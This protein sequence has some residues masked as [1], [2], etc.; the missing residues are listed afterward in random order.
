MENIINNPNV[1][2]KS[3]EKDNIELPLTETDYN[4]IEVENTIL[5][6]FKEHGFS[7]STSELF[8]GKASYF[9]SIHYKYAYNEIIH[10][11]S[12]Y[13]S[14]I[15]GFPWICFWILNILEFSKEKNFDMNLDLKLKFVDV[16]KELQNPEGG[17]YGFVKGSSHLISTYAGVMSVA[18]LAIPEA[19]DLIDRK[20]LKEFLL[21]MKNNDIEF[22]QKN[23]F[24]DKNNN[25]LIYHKDDKNNC[26][27][28]FTANP[29]SF[30]NHFNGESD[31][32]SI[33]CALTSAYILNIIDDDLTKNVVEYIRECQT[34][35]GGFGPE[36]FCEAHG[37][38]SYCAIASLILL[39]SLD[40]I[41][42]DAFLRWLCMRQMT[43]EGGFNGRTNKLVDSCYSFW[44][45]SIF[46]LLKMGDEKFSFDDEL[47]YDQLS[48]QAYILF[49]CQEENGGIKDKPGKYPDLFHTNYASSGLILS[50]ECLVDH[51]KVAL[52]NELEKELGDKKHNPIFNLED[53]K[54]QKCL[55][56]FKMKDNDKNNEEKKEE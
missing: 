10:L 19:Y 54:V 15:S 35:E 4:Q 28:F 56:Y 16:L 22:K 29:G 43:K 55:K 45:G 1:Q 37:G 7:T 8:S 50:M 2:N 47:L 5:K 49:C 40:K 32:R 31:L 25:F 26:S 41:N 33:Y 44:Q 20:K 46:S 9:N 23:T 38:Y 12:D 11:S 13:F 52:S 30:E 27:K 14:L 48:L 17:F 36:P 51:C 34:Y 24:L 42:V 39:N 53:E 21:K 6:I 18:N 3:E